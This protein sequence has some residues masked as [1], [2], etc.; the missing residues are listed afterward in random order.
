MN[1]CEKY[2]SSLL[3]ILSISI[4]LPEKSK[5]S[6]VSC[7]QNAKNMIFVPESDAVAESYSFIVP[8]D[9]SII[10]LEGSPDENVSVLSGRKSV[11]LE[12]LSLKVFDE[13]S[14]AFYSILESSSA[15]LLL[16]VVCWVFCV[17]LW[18]NRS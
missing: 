17:N 14:G 2:L 11:L 6:V 7:N 3:L 16:A 10:V 1:Y 8:A 4:I 15:S 18:G 5:A 9:G 13:D 12:K